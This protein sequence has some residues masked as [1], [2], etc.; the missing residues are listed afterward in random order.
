MDFEPK[1]EQE[2]A[3]DTLIVGGGII[4]LSSAFYLAQKGCQVAVL[5]KRQFGAEGTG[6]TAGGVRQRGRDRR[7]IPLAMASVALWAE[8][9]DLLGA[10]VYYRRGGNISVALNDEEMDS[11]RIAAEEEQTLGLEVQLLDRK[12]LL[13]LVPALSERC[14]GGSFCP[15]DGYAEPEPVI[16]AY[17]GALERLGVE[18]FPETEALEFKVRNGRIETVNC[19]R[20]AFHP[21]A[22]LIAAGPWAPN[23]CMKFG[24][25]LPIWPGRAQLVESAPVGRI[26]DQFLVFDGQQV[27][28]RPTIDERIHFGSITWVTPSNVI[29]PQ[30][31]APALDRKTA[32]EAMIPPLAGMAVNRTWSGLLDLTPDGVPIMGPIPGLSDAFLAAGFCGHGFALGPIVGKTMAECIVDGETSLS[33]EDFHLTRFA[34]EMSF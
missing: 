33:I 1:P 20:I 27:Y 24:L 28:C 29:E 19:E 17:L 18:L 13:D 6:R 16:S 15:T 25:P 11:L 8:L 14:V 3:I 7:E 12:A 5:E 2:L 26:F 31:M 30:T 4:G 32:L 22:V 9:E 10:P 21:Q 23:L 34:D